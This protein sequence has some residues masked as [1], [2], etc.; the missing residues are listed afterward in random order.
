MAALVALG[1]CGG[2]PEGEVLVSG[3]VSVMVS[4]PRD[5]GMMALLR[6]RLEVVD[7]C[8]GV[9]G[10]PV[11]WPHGTQVVAAEPLTVDVPGEGETTVGDQ[12]EIGGGTLEREGDE[13]FEPGDVTVPEQCDAGRAFLAWAR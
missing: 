11:V 4:E 2:G 1:G 3:D 10:L 7:G 5:E 9:A 8:L 6:G 13:P 12:V